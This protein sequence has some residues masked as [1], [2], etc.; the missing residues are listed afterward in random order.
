M[1]NSEHSKTRRRLEFLA[2]LGVVE[3]TNESGKYD[4]QKIDEVEAFKEENELDFMPS[5]ISS[6]TEAKAIMNSLTH[7]RLE[8]L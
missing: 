7:S 1:K 2:K 8:N 3:S 4:V 5:V 6:D